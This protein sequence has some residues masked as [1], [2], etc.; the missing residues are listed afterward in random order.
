MHTPDWLRKRMMPSIILAAFGVITAAAAPVQRGERSPLSCDD[1][2]VLRTVGAGLHFRGAIPEGY[3]PTESGLRNPD[4]GEELRVTVEGG[5]GEE[6]TLRVEDT[7]IEMR[8]IRRTGETADGWRCAADFTLHQG[9]RTARGDA[10]YTVSV[11][12][13]EF[14]IGGAFT[15]E[16]VEIRF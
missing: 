2:V 1:P 7:R 10:D 15:I 6:S 3:R 11:S 14:R 5:P 12:G 13:L 8:N 9:D 4:T 16:G